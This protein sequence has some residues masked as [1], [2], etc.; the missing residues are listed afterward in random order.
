MTR[1]TQRREPPAVRRLDHGEIDRVGG[2][3]TKTTKAETQHYTVKL[4]NANIASVDFR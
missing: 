3:N 4:T 1:D 2:G